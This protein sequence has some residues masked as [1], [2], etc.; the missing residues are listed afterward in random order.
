MAATISLCMIVKN[1]ERYLDRCLS[2]IADLVDEIIIVDTGSKDNTKAIAARHAA[3]IFDFPWIYDFAAARNYAFDQ[4]SMQYQMW[5]DADDVI[6]DADRERFKALKATLDD[7]V[8][9]VMA[10]YAVAFDR[11]GECV[12]LYNR[13]WTLPRSVDTI[14]QLALS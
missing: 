1:E 14:K 4:A 7:D 10:K 11:S 13:E 12:S 8:D 5:L 6:K 3:R 9:V 2:S